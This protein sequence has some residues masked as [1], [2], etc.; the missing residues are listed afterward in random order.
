VSRPLWALDELDRVVGSE[1]L[2]SS[3]TRWNVGQGEWDYLHLLPRK[4]L[5]RLR[6][7]RYM[8]VGGMQPD[9]LAELIAPNVAGCDS[10]DAAMEWYVKTCLVAVAEARLIAGRKHRLRVA[11]RNGHQNYYQYR[12]ESAKRQGYDSVYKMRK[13]R[14]W[15]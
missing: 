12:T 1:A 5:R 7:A 3:P 2:A 11:Q 9:V 8:R 13:G 14:G 4:T 6:G 15:G 10:T